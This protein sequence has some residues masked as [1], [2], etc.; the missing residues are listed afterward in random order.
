MGIIQRQTIRGTIWTYLG[1]I[2][3]FIT[4]ALIFPRI[5]STDQI[6]LLGI[7]VSYSYI[8]AQLASMG[9][10]RIIVVMFPYFKDERSKHHGF[11]PLMA[12]V[13]GAGLVIALAIFMLIRPWLMQNANDSSG[14]FPIFVN[15]L[16]PLT[17][18]TLLF[19][20]FDTYYK[21]LYNATRG[22][23]LKE[24]IQ[25]V[26]ILAFICIYYFGLIDFR[27]YLVLYVVAFAIP[28]AILFVS[29]LFEKELTLRPDFGHPTRDQKKL[30]TSLGFYGILIGF[31]GM[32]ILNVDRIM[33]ERMMGLSSTGIYTTMA[34]FATLII[35][36]SRALLKISDPVISQ[37]WKD[38]DMANLKDNYYRSSLGQFIFG[39]LILVGLWGNIG[40]INRILPEQFSE[41]NLVVLFVGLAFL[42]DMA[43]GTA[44]YIL[45][46]SAL[47]KYQT[48]FIMLLVIFV[49]VTNFLLIPVW[50]ITGAAVATF[51]SK[52]LN[53]YM[54][55]HFLK[56][57][58]G[59]Q[60]YNLKYVG[61]AGIALSAYF[62]AFFIPS[63]KN[64][65]LDIILRST[66]MAGVFS[67]LIL[68]FKISED[69][70]AFYRNLM[71]RLLP[72]K[73]E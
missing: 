22:I 2:V 14:L 31:S 21:V 3:G 40:N 49:I 50:G 12:L 42:T 15:Y 48:Y 8:F 54:R 13:C 62:A 11:F 36:P 20:L 17:V 24:L 66:V 29:L 72:G 26:A 44:G 32:V 35:I 64:L 30:M 46:N 56:R 38:K 63:L 61:V 39:S 19:T 16:V 73:P 18:F 25:R 57:K 4:T 7:L 9:T 41:G 67:A 34:Y 58:Y 5:L 1:I 47:F 33:V 65:Y 37:A 10:G 53:N 59:L 45:A 69:A 27:Q 71:R 52:L 51:I 60:P 23:L 70:T 28:A 55:F 68:G 6:G 43:T